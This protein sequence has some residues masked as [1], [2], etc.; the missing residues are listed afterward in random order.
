MVAAM[1][2]LGSDTRLQQQS[3]YSASQGFYQNQSKPPL[4]DQ[5]PGSGM[6]Y[7][8][9]NSMGME[10]LPS[11]KTSSSNNSNLV[12]HSSSPAGLF[13]NINSEF[14]NGML[15]FYT[16]LFDFLERMRKMRS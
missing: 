11:M 2:N 10:R 15:F 12:R 6:N 16:L 3:N 5:K 1:N 13:S 7:R 8:S 14:E 9:M 4:P